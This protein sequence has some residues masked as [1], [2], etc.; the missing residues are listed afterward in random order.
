M[1]TWTA[2]LFRTP[3]QALH[4]GPNILSGHLTLCETGTASSVVILGSLPHGATLVDWWVRLRTGAA[5]QGF[6]LGTSNSPSGIAA[7]VTASITIS[8]SGLATEVI[9]AGLHSQ[10]YYRAPHGGDLMPVKISLSDDAIPA[11]TP[12]WLRLRAAISASLQLTYALFYTMDG[13]L[14]HTTIR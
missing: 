13:M 3:I 10:F 7:M 6:E 12:I 4:A 9:L 2:S 5:D 14:G 8:M 11:P 1:A